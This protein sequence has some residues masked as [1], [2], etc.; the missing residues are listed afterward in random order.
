MRRCR[1]R[2]IVPRMSERFYT[3][4]PLSPGPAEL[5]GPEAH[6]LAAV[7]RVRPGDLVC[8]FNGD[9]ADYPARVVD[10]AKKRVSLEILERLAVSRELGISLEIAAPLPKGDR[11]QFLV[12]KLTELGVRAFTPLV[13]RRSVIQ[14]KENTLEKLHRYVIEASKQCGRNV[15]MRIEPAAEWT[16]FAAPRGDEIRL[17]AQPGSETKPHRQGTTYRCV[18]GPEGGFAPEEIALAQAHGWQEI[19]LGP[20]ILRVETA[21][22]ALAIKVQ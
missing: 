14:P 5:D 16:D 6:H 2:R 3:N 11:T 18:V 22:L 9:G 21:A 12:E 15:L 13:C 1:A 7:C 10:V 17:I 8:L 19:G 4:C 20:R